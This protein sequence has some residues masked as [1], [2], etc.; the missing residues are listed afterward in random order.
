MASTAVS[1]ACRPTWE[2]PQRLVDAGDGVLGVCGG[3]GERA[4]ESL[5]AEAF[6][7]A[8]GGV[9]DA[10]GVEDE[11]RAGRDVGRTRSQ[12]RGWERPPSSGP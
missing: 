2:R 9:Q 3:A 12:R 10:V 5:F 11:D 6:S 4:R 1:S 8:T 7:V